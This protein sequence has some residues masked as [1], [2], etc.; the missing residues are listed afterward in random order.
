MIAFTMFAAT[1]SP[2]EPT[3]VSGPGAQGSDHYSFELV[4]QYCLVFQP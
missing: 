2:Q 1:R 3:Y 4:A